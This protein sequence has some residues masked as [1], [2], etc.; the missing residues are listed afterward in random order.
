MNKIK[1]TKFNVCLL[2]EGQ[3]GKTC[4]ALVYTGHQ[5]DENTL[6][7]VGLD[8]FLDIKK[9]NGVEYKFKIF[10][11]AG[12]ERYRSISH[13]TIQI[14]DG[15][16]IVFSVINRSSFEQINYWINVIED[17]TDIKK[18]AIILIGNKIDVGKR[19]V[20]HEEALNFAKEKN[21]DYYE[22][23][24]KTGFRIKEIFNKLYEKVYQNHVKIEKVDGGEK[25]E[26][27]KTVVL[28]ENKVIDDNN[29]KK[30]KHGCCK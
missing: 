15:F 14:S 3:V 24:A 26:E 19:E 2:G 29:N 27:T 13:Q 30:E 17:N 22:T 9:I 20:S 7:T 6:M 1:R 8:N 21:I 18:K 11:T 4:I 25:I 12:Q 23:S 28:D 16:L 10:D 5:F